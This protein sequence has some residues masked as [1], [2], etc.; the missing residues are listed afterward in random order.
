MK[1][2]ISEPPKSKKNSMQIIKLGNRWAVT[3]SKQ[4][5]EYEK[6]CGKYLGDWKGEPIDYPCEVRCIYYMPSRRRVDMTNLMAAT[7]DV[8]VKYGILEDDNRDII[9]S[10]DGSR[11]FYDKENPR[12]EIE[13]TPYKGEYDIWKSK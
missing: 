5:K 11:V 12:T 7:H 4:Y 3:Q 9:C 8:L 10:V 6:A 13:I 2:V 1:I